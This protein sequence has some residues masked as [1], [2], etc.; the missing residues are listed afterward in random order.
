MGR[1]QEVRPALLNGQSALR[2]HVE[3]HALVPV[4]PASAGSGTPRAGGRGRG[5]GRGAAKADSV[6]GLAGAGLSRGSQAAPAAR[7]AVKVLRCARVPATKE[8]PAQVGCLWLARSPA[9]LGRAQT[10]P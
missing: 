8:L 7:K 2:L 5:R 4:P 1:L 3:E 10:V 6:R 9:A